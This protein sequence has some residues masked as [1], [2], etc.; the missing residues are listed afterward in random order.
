MTDINNDR[1]YSKLTTY[2]ATNYGVRVR[3][4]DESRLMRFIGWLMFFNRAFMTRYTTT[5]GRTVYFPTRGK[6]NWETLAHEAV[7]VLDYANAPVRFALGY[8][9]PQG[10]AAFAL[11]ALAA[12]VIPVFLVTLLFLVAAGP[13]PSPWRLKR[14]RRGFRMTIACS[15]LRSGP[16]PTRSPD[17]QDWLAREIYCGYG[18]YRMK[19]DV[20]DARMMAWQDTLYGELLAAPSLSGLTG[21]REH[22]E[23]LKAI[24]SAI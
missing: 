16:V 7:H 17:F 23:I 22:I 10:L 2:L 15:N 3:Y 5:L 24:R 9:M 19:R 14:E 18:Y 4:K 1:V 12:F 13:W 11:I 6:E 8:V 21:H 20:G